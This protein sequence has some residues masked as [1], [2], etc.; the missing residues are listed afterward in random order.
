MYRCRR[1]SRYP[2]PDEDRGPDIRVT[3][4]IYIC[5]R[6]CDGPVVAAQIYNPKRQPPPVLK[7]KPV[8]SQIAINPLTRSSQNNPDPRT[9]ALDAPADPLLRRYWER[10]A[11]T[12]DDHTHV[13]T[14]SL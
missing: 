2:E 13:F 14:G 1:E 3:L 11:P 6:F 7:T 4:R 9:M 10:H 5:G 8:T 12:P